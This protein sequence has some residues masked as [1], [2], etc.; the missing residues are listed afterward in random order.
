MYDDE[1]AWLSKF[2]E[3]RD[4]VYLNV[5][6]ELVQIAQAARSGNFEIVDN[7]KLSPM[8][9]WK[10]AFLYS[11]KKLIPIYDRKMLEYIALQKGMNDAKSAKISQIQNFLLKEE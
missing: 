8:F 10:V 3:K 9:K 1:Y 11:E 6:E 5:R 4:D 7:S 2:G